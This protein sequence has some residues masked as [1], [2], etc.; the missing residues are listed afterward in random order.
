MQS[1]LQ[2]GQLSYNEI[3]YEVSV[4]EADRQMKAAV[5]SS[6]IHSPVHA[7]SFFECYGGGEPSWAAGTTRIGVTQVLYILM[8]L[9]FKPLFPFLT[10]LFLACR[11]LAPCFSLTSGLYACNLPC[12]SFCFFS[13]GYLQPWVMWKH[14]TH[15]H[16]F[17]TKLKFIHAWFVCIVRHM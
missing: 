9:Q 5:C 14:K 7:C 1:S 6:A 16:M 12:S 15:T 8:M 4:E 13:R 2:S 17:R 11:K 3:P 10:Y